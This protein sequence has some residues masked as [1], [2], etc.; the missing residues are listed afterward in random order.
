MGFS[1][2][3]A[4]PW[5]R[6][7]KERLRP[8]LRRLGVDVVAY[9][10]SASALAR[11]MRLFQHHGIDLVFDVGANAGQYA[12]ALREA[13]FEGAIVSFEPLAEAFAR[14]Q[15]RAAGDRLWRCVNVAISDRSGRARFHVDDADGQCSSFLEML[16]ALKQALEPRNWHHSVREVEA[17]TLD[18]VVARFAKPATTLYVKMDVQGYEGRIFAGASRSLE[19]IDGFQMELSL[20]PLYDGE[21]LLPDMITLL[22]ERGFSLESIEP[23]K[24]DA[25]TGRLLQADCIFFR[26]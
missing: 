10:P 15:D 26:T 13:G 22:G 23:G 2:V 14:L 9:D 16:P 21:T 18:D 19:R 25:R 5:V 7:V 3:L 20:A 11:R 8:A 6:A 17:V 4:T 1:R 12:A 24:A